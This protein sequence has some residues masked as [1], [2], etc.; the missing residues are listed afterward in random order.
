[1]AKALFDKLLSNVCVSISIPRTQ[2]IA[3][4]S[5]SGAAIAQLS[6][7]YHIARMVRESATIFSTSDTSLPQKRRKLTISMSE[8]IGTVAYLTSTIMDPASASRASTPASLLPVERALADALAE[9]VE[10]GEA[11]KM[12]AQ[13]D[14]RLTE[15]G[16]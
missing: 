1:M 12:L 5:I 14:T 16:Y 11:R 8:S 15:S 4:G 7:G 9:S 6:H 10:R 13:A 2:N 3:Y